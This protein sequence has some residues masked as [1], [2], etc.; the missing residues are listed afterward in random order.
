ML[1]IE[2]VVGI[3]KN[4]RTGEHWGYLIEETIPPAELAKIKTS[5]ADKSAG[6]QQLE[7][8]AK[9]QS[10]ESTV[11]TD[12]ESKIEKMLADYAANMRKTTDEA[13]ARLKKN[14]NERTPP[15]APAAASLPAEIHTMSF[16]ELS[17]ASREGRITVIQFTNELDWR[18]ANPEAHRQLVEK[19]EALKS[20]HKAEEIGLTAKYS[21]LTGVEKQKLAIAKADAIARCVA[22]IGELTWIPG[23]DQ[24][25]RKFFQEEINREYENL[26][27]WCDGDEKTAA[28]EILKAANQPKMDPKAQA[29]AD[30][31]RM[32]AGGDTPEAAFARAILKAESD[33]ALRKSNPSWYAIQKHQE[34]QAGPDE[35]EIELQWQFVERSRY[36]HLYR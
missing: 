28:D 8:I 36:P 31:R 27:K 7:K 3:I 17:K 20:R 1:T 4:A 6:G 19:A 21:Y 23:K 32:A 29:E 14:L 13:I 15:A 10:E 12:L 24:A 9:R 34:A 25:E 35:K 5:P 33:E 26:V 11:T 2:K 30:L 22:R 18:K 16:E